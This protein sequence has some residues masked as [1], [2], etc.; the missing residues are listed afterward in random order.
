MKNFFFVAIIALMSYQNICAWDFGEA[1][2]TLYGEKKFLIRDQYLPRTQKALDA[3][4][5]NIS[6]LTIL[7]TKIDTLIKQ[8]S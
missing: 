7:E 3:I 5:A 1:I 2:S 6:Q 8:L 4:N